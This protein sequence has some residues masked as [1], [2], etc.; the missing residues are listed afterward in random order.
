MYMHRTTSAVIN[1][2]R[3]A[4]ITTLAYID[5]I[6]GVQAPGDAQAG[7]THCRRVL[8]DLG[9]AEQPDKM[10]PPAT[11]MT[12]LGVAFDTDSMVMSVPPEKIKECLKLARMWSTKTSCTRSQLRS[13]LGKLFH[14]AQCCPILRL[15]VNRMLETLRNAP[16]Q[17]SINI[18]KSFQ[19]DINWIISYLPLY[20]GIQMIPYKPTL[21]APITVDSCLTGCGGHF[22]NNI[23]AAPFPTFVTEERHTICDLEMLNILLAVKL[24]APSLGGHVVRIQCDN[25]AAVS[26][27]QTGR[28]RASFLLSCAREIWRYT[29]MYK[30]EIRVEHLPGTQNTLADAL[31]RC[32][33]DSSC[34]AIVDTFIQKHNP[35]VFPVDEYMFR[36]CKNLKDYS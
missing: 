20:N 15:F 30:F 25:A 31:S 11:S 22:A 12:W 5:D 16:E 13:Y 29:A 9:L 6:A 33:E 23:Y 35:K 7:L 2:A 17:G 10:T 8:R 4:G 34:Q 24:W 3:Q 28:G 27:L 36:L 19:A 1:I 18:P 26:I 32:H 14:I 21:S